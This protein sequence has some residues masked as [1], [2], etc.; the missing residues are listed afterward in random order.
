[1]HTTTTTTRQSQ[2]LPFEEVCLLLVV[3]IQAADTENL[4]RKRN[5]NDPLSPTLKIK[6]IKKNCTYRLASCELQIPPDA[7]LFIIEP[8]VQHQHGETSF[9]LF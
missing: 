5:Q 8:L 2:Y 3:F 1:M 6:Y 4:E 9:Y 7:L